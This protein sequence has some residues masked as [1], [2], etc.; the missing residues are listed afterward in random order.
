M[1][2]GPPGQQL[3]GSVMAHYRGSRSIEIRREVTGRPVPEFILAV[4]LVC[5][6][7]EKKNI[8]DLILFYA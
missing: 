4:S 1:P 7:L 2:G 8:K 5:P 6:R 3:M